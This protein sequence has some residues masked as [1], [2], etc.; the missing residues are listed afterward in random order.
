MTAEPV[1]P[2][3]FEI[4]RTGMGDAVPFARHAS[5]SLD[6]IGDATSR[7]SLPEAEHL[8]NHLGTVHAGALFTLAETA[9][10]AAMAGAFAPMLFDI[11]PVVSGARIDYLRPATGA[12]RAVAQLAVPGADLRRTL[13]DERRVSVDAEVEIL[14]A[15]ERVVARFT[16]TWVVRHRPARSS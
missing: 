10:G 13:L 3:L 8:V 11:R 9:S 15:S 6:E 5:V 7:A 12:L 16:A 4:V 14:D 1:D 2:G